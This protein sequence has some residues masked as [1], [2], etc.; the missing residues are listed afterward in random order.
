VT[1]DGK[2]I[3]ESKSMV[4]VWDADDKLLEITTYNEDGS[5]KDKFVYSYS[6]AG[7]R[8]RTVR[9]PSG[10]DDV[11]VIETIFGYDE[12]GRLSEVSHVKGGSPETRT[13]HKYDAGG[14]KIKEIRYGADGLVSQVATYDR[15]FD[16][17]GNW[18]TETKT[19]LYPQR[20]NRTLTVVTRR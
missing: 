16:Q 1:S 6:A 15:E 20:D 4:E 19:K 11:P 14:N 12:A 13:L 9:Y 18:I 10:L 8:V 7:K 17:Q 3:V 5:L 2:R